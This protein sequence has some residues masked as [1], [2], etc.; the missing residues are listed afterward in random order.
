MTFFGKYRGKV[1]SNE[2]PLLL[3]RLQVSVPAVLPEG[4]YCW[5]MPCVPYAGESVGFLAIPPA[6][7]NVW[8]EFEGGDPDYPIW[9][10]CFWGEGEIPLPAIPDVKVLKTGAITLTMSDVPGE[11]GFT[12]EV[13]P[14]AITSPLRMVFGI[15]GIE[16]SN[17]SASIKITLDSIS[18]DH[19]ASEI[20]I[21]PDGISAESTPSAITVRQAGISLENSAMSVEVTPASVSVNDGALEVT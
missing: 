2:D 9:S 1:Q 11:G 19:T 4:V 17:G 21:A 5:A 20:R 6:Q 8:V 7:A 15:D 3:G 18:L 13:G 16:L 12:L 14:P 10:G